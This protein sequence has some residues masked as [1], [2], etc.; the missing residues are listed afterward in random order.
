[1]KNRSNEIHSNEICIRREPPVLR[2]FSNK[3]SVTVSE[4]SDYINR[5]KKIKI[6]MHLNEMKTYCTPSRIRIAQKM[7]KKFEKN[8]IRCQTKVY[9]PKPAL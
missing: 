7:E 8:L 2:I 1:L 5:R 3:R 4:L 6:S 9:L